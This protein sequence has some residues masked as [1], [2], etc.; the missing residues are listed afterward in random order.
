MVFKNLEISPIYIFLKSD[1]KVI[2]RLKNDELEQAWS[3]L[4]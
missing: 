1:Q 3:I 4:D 2:R